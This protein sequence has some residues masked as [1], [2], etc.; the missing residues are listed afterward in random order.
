MDQKHLRLGLGLTIQ[1]SNGDQ[2]SAVVSGLNE[3]QQSINVEWLEAGE[4]KA[5][6][7]EVEAVLNLNSDLLPPAHWKRETPSSRGGGTSSATVHL[8]TDHTD[9]TPGALHKYYDENG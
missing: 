6:E 9:T 8:A 4:T 1:R 2:H 7:M 3:A 5:K